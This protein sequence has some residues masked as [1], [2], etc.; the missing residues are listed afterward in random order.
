MAD[1]ARRKSPQS[2]GRNTARDDRRL[3]AEAVIPRVTPSMR[4]SYE[5]E[6]TM[7]RGDAPTTTTARFRSAGSRSRRTDA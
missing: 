5:A 3:A 1:D 7:P 6:K 2:G 4:A